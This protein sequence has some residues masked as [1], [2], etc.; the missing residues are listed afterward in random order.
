MPNWCM[1]TYKLVG[2]KEEIADLYKKLEA[3]QTIHTA[4]YF[5]CCEC[6]KENKPMPETPPELIES[7]YIYLF[8]GS[9]IKCFG[10][11]YKEVRCS[12]AMNFIE[13]LEDNVIKLDAETEW[14]DMPE[15]WDLVV[16]KYK[17]IKYYFIAE[18]HGHEYYISNDTTGEYFREKYYVYQKDGDSDYLEDEIA[19]RHVIAGRIGVDKIDSMEE[20]DQLLKEHNEKK[21][22]SEIRYYEFLEPND[23]SEQ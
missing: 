17:T 3:L 14:R 21:P 12:G 19:L 20:L 23:K 9:I 2:D 8:L 6:Y 18:E 13:L 15:V 22:E 11:D 7:T 10:G 5:E 16:S 1:T 4:H